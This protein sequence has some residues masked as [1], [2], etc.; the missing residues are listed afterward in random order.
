[1][2]RQTVV[3]LY[4]L[5]LIAVV[6]AVDVLFFKRLFWARL[7]ANVG[8]VLVFAAFYLRFLNRP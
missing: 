7:I 8:I 1:M 4:V 5:F 6:V 2:G 3:V